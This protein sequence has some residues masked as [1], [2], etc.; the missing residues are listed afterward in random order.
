VV[1]VLASLHVIRASVAL[2][3]T[4]AFSRFLAVVVQHVFHLVMAQAALLV[5]GSL[6]KMLL[7]GQC[8]V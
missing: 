5:V 1:K 4:R 2:L 7:E 8:L 3:A 6:V